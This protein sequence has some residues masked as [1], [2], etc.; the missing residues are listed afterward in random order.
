DNLLQD[1]PVHTQIRYQPLQ[2]PILLA[3]LSQL[4]QFAHPYPGILPFP[5]IVSRLA[6]P[7]L[8]AYLVHSR[9]RF[10]L[11]QYRHDLFFRVG[12]LG[13][14]PC[15]L[16]RTAAVTQNPKTV[17]K[18]TR[19][20]L[21]RTVLERRGDDAKENSHGRADRGGTAASGS[22]SASGRRLPQGGDQPSDVLSLETE[23][24]RGGSERVT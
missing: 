2:P 12:F 24:Y 16:V 1:L 10:H 18:E 13:H 6:N 19:V 20:I 4:T 14:R 15:L 7:H 5:Q 21:G 22:G 9:S 23:V 17:A 8:A 11:P 3:Q